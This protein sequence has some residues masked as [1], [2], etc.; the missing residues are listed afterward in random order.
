MKKILVSLLVL[1]SALY[2]F[3]ETVVIDEEFDSDDSNLNA[4]LVN[5][6]DVFYETNR[7]S[8]NGSE[9][10]KR[11]NDWGIN[12]EI[13]RFESDEDG[14]FDWIEANIFGLEFGRVN[15]ANNYVLNHS[16]ATYKATG[17]AKYGNFYFKDLYGPQL[18]VSLFSFAFTFGSKSGFDWLKMSMDKDFTYKEN[19]IF[20][21]FVLEPYFSINLK[22]TVKVYASTEFDFPILRVRFVKDPYYED[23][24]VLW[25]WFKNDVPVSYRV[26]TIVFF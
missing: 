3:A 15:T 13:G 21:D 10:A 18:N 17:D 23:Y 26:G 24:R 22:H 5:I 14:L 19:R 9:Y 1:I 2:C 20:F 25:D 12:G 16:Y 6:G 11:M 8:L 7:L 4:L